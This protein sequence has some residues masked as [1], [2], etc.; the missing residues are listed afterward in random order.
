[1]NEAKQLSLSLCTVIAEVLAKTP[2]A[3]DRLLPEQCILQCTDKLSAQVALLQSLILPVAKI[4]YS[5]NQ[6]LRGLP[7]DK[8]HTC[9]FVVK[10][11][12]PSPARSPHTQGIT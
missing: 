6:N 8:P 4:S 3:T 7:V 9:L 11:L 12:L 5:K 10:N 2:A 1:M